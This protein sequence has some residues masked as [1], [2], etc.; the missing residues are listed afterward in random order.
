MGKEE[1]QN[2]MKPFM[3]E[4]VVGKIYEFCGCVRSRRC[5]F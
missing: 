1:K 4:M 2:G 3:A 5:A